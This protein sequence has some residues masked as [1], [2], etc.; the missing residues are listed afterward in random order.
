[1]ASVFHAV[2]SPSELRGKFASPS[3]MM[4]REV[5]QFRRPSISMAAWQKGP[6]PASSGASG[7]AFGFKR[8][9][10]SAAAWKSGGSPA[11]S[12]CAAEED[13]LFLEEEH[14][15]MTIL[16]LDEAKWD[17][18]CDYTTGDCVQIVRVGSGT[19]DAYNRA[20]V[21]ERRVLKHD[22]ITM[23]NGRTEPQAMLHAIQDGGYLTMQIVQPRR[24]HL[25]LDKSDRPLG[26][27]LNYQEGISTCLQVKSVIGGGAVGEYNASVAL[28]D[29]VT[30]GCFVESA[31]GV[32]GSGKALMAELRTSTVVNLVILRYPG[33]SQTDAETR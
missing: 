18:E 4:K 1:M 15:E 9:S 20:V 27:T 13:D 10:L 24:L 19:V 33:V 28:E 23:V 32:S 8:P 30:E 11:L 16:K 7:E 22:L 31:N 29:Q 21:V 6:A 14:F 12:P 17:L 26:L 5:F 3:K 2:V 25:R